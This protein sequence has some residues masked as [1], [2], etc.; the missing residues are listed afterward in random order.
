MLRKLMQFNL[1]YAPLI[2]APIILFSESLFTGKVLYWGTPALQFIPWRYYVW[3]Q[4]SLGNFPLWN[5]YNGLGVPLVANYQLALFYPPGWLIYLICWVGN[6]GLLGWA[7]TLLLVLHMIWM[8][9]GMSVFTRKLGMSNLGRVVSSL[10]FCLS[11]YFTAR[12]GFFSMIWTAAWIPWI[13]YGIEEVIEGGPSLRSKWGKTILLSI[14]LAMLLLAGHAQ[15][16]WY[17]LLFASAWYVMRIISKY[18]FRSLLPYLQKFSLVI[19]ISLMLSVVQLL[20]T[21]EY[22]TQSQRAL[23]VDYQSAMTFSFW[24]WRVLGLFLPDMFGNP[25]YGNYWGYASYWEDAIYIG[26]FPAIIGLCTLPSLIKS[27]KLEIT[28]EER[29]RLLFLWILLPIAFILAL[30]KNT[31]IFPFLYHSIPSFDMFQAPSRYMIWFVLALSLLAGIGVDHWKLPTGK[32]LYWTRLLTAGCFAITLGSILSEVFLENISSTFIRSTSVAGILG[33]I[34]GILT[35]F[36]PNR[37]KDA[38]GGIWMTLVV[39]LV[40]GDLLFAGWKYN[41]VTDS[42]I[43]TEQIN[44]PTDDKKINYRRIFIPPEDE[45]L[46]KF[47]RFFR[48]SDY[49]PLENL[50][51]LRNVLLPDIN[52]LSQ[53][54]MVN[55]F[56]PMQPDRFSRWLKFLLGLNQIDQN[57]LLRKIGVRYIVH[58]DIQKE[59]GVTITPI[60]SDGGIYWFPCAILTKDKSESFHQLES[61]EGNAQ[62]RL[63]SGPIIIEARETSNIVNKGNCLVQGSMKINQ[64]NRLENQVSFEVVTTQDGWVVLADTWYPGWVVKLDGHKSSLYPADYLFRGL[65]VPSGNHKIQFI[66]QPLS[67]WLGLVLSGISWCIFLIMGLARNYS[68]KSNV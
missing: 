32:T 63:T 14:Y 45:Y 43:Y 38:K 47:R 22:L 12:A 25:G 65:Y 31:P 2:I 16:A 57:V 13:L 6:T 29:A 52:L 40:T 64:V 42:L 33:L 10:A 55:N 19:F 24:P 26:V 17:G 49:A 11:G 50:L 59:N 44:L 4:I 3:N 60:L 21:Y 46:L 56:D 23:A 58:L 67:F 37:W 39:I 30:G 51:T 36:M 41:P 35:L 18:G 20:P 61:L 68:T 34:T 48:F 1:W 9:I 54:P 62:A 7:H 8:G 15:L 53:I 66:Y 27:K 28:K 5:P